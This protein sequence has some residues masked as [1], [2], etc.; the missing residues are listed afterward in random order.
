[1]GDMLIRGINPELKRRLEESAR[2]NKRSLSEEAVVL[3]QKGFATQFASAEKA[4]DRLYSLVGDD[5][6][7]ND[8]IQEIARSRSEADR[9]PPDFR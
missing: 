9:G 4:G 3:M 1:M 2:L 6:F 8:E 7:T 5:R